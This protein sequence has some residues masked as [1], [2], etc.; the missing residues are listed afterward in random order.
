MEENSDE[1]QKNNSWRF[2]KKFTCA[3]WQISDLKLTLIRQGF[4]CV[5]PERRVNS[6]YFDDH[7]LSNY[8]DNLLGIS[9]RTKYRLRFYGERAYNNPRFEK[10]IKES[11]FNT[12]ETIKFLGELQDFKSLKFPGKGDL[13]PL[14]HVSYS[15]DYFFNSLTGVRVTIDKDLIYAS[16]LSG[17]SI[18]DRE[19]V[20]EFKSDQDN[21]VLNV[22]KIL[23]INTRNS[24]YCKSISRLGFASE[25]Y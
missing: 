7:K 14:T 9:E 1:P 22:P 23:S 3:G 13:Q 18:L 15:R 5:F 4:R 12:K 2:E 16:L 25:L 24:K 8:Y 20:V 21:P 19:L 6:I 11:D 17:T 10:K